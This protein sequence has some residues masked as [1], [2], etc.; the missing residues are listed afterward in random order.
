MKHYT[1]HFK[2]SFAQLN[3]SRV[4]V[5]TRVPGYYQ[6]GVGGW[7]HQ[8]RVSYGQLTV[9]HFSEVMATFFQGDEVEKQESRLQR[10]PLLSYSEFNG[11]GNLQC[12]TAVK[13]L[14]HRK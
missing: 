1:L 5:E 14:V 3:L 9:T 13:I 4:T 6:R 8:W 10:A 12:N 7:I 11:Q 2:A